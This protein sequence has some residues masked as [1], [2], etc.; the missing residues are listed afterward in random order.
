MLTAALG[1]ATPF[2]AWPAAVGGDLALPPPGDFMLCV[3]LLILALTASDER[4]AGFGLISGR[5]IIEPG[6]VFRGVGDE[7]TFG[8]GCG[9]GDDA[10]FSRRLPS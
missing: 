3:I 9:G 8:S 10:N 7:A 4:N 1:S 2:V 6:E 5:G